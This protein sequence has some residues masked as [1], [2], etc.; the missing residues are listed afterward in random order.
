MSSEKPITFLHCAD[1]HLGKS[2]ADMRDDPETG[3][4]FLALDAE[5]S[6]IQ[7]VQIAIRT[8]VNFVLLAGDM[9]DRININNTDIQGGLKA[10]KKLSDAKI[11]FVVVAGNHDKPFTKGVSSPILY[12]NIL[13]NCHAIVKH[14]TVTLD[15]NGKKI[16]IHGIPYL[17]SNAEEDY[18]KIVD[19]LV[20]KSKADYQIILSHQSLEGAVPG[21]EWSH[22]TEPLIPRSVFP[23]QID[24][25]AMGHIHKRQTLLHPNFKNI[26]M[27]YSGSTL[28][29]DFGERDY[30]KGITIVKLPS[31]KLK[32]IF[33]KCRTFKEVNLEFTNPGA[34][35]DIENKIKNAIEENFDSDIFLGITLTGKIRQVFRTSTLTNKY[36]HAYRSKFAGLKIY[37][38]QVEWIT[39]SGVS[40]TY[41]ESWVKSPGEELRAALEKKKLSAAQEKAL[42]NLGKEIINEVR[43]NS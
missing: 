28:I 11:P 10:L 32:K 5:A 23:E 25:V 22:R 3:R 16:D 15:I 36:S 20:N 38:T 24:Y 14:R 37:N 12:V 29:T 6:F 8:K 42:Y 43:E 31:K 18:Q 41:G 4:N 19:L 33:V 30:D 17:K 27:H 26:Q 2:H 34:S 21:I 7:I 39:D 40:S 35:F 9:F 1:T 13:D